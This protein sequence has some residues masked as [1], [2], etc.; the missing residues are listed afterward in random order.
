MLSFLTPPL[1]QVGY[2][3]SVIV[4]RPDAVS[5]NALKAVVEHAAA[6]LRAEGTPRLSWGLAPLTGA[7]GRTVAGPLIGRDTAWA[8]LAKAVAWT[9]ANT[10]YPFQV[11]G[12]SKTRWGGGFEL[13]PGPTPASPPHYVCGEAGASLPMSYLVHTLRA[14]TPGAILDLLVALRWMGFVNGVQG[15]WVSFKLDFVVRERG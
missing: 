3:N 7:N 11:A 10:L 14:P 8:G 4:S 12:A 5:R 13:A 1:P 2:Y 6:T 9:D 15:V